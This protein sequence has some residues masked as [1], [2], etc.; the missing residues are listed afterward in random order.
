MARKD[1]LLRLHQRLLAKRESL[2]KK[3]IDE[4]NLSPTGRSGTGDVVDAAIDGEQNELD[5]QLAALESREL[6]A[7][8]H[9]IEAIRN[10]RYGRCEVCDHSIPI[11]RLQALPFS[12]SCIDCQR[13]QE[14]TGEGR[15]DFDADWE[16]A[17][18]MEGRMNDSNLTLRD[19]DVD[20]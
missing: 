16:S 8:D 17:F 1:A 4:L 15:A 3:L 12:A 19:I 6:T 10:G 2:R 5:S 7:I 11:A 9:A 20:R 13:K 18:E 14:E